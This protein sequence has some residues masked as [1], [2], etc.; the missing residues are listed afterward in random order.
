MTLPLTVDQTD[1]RQSEAATL[2]LKKKKNFV[3][4]LSNQSEGREHLVVTRIREDFGFR[5]SLISFGLQLQLMIV[6]TVIRK[7]LLFKYF[8]FL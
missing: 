1:S 8:R 7:T 6:M 2:P 4:Q 5:F 3:S